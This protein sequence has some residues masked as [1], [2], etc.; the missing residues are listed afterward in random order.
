MISL[1]WASDGL[2]TL[3]THEMERI[4]TAY[5]SDGARSVC[6]ALIRAVEAVRDPHQDNAT[7]LVVRLADPPAA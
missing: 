4:V 5:G 7:V 6:D 2:Q 3:E 1:F